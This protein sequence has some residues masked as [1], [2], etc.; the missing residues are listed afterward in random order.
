MN[1]KDRLAT[2]HSCLRVGQKSLEELARQEMA[3]RNAIIAQER[4]QQLEDS[5]GV[6]AALYRIITPY[7]SFEE[8]LAELAENEPPFTTPYAAKT[9]TGWIQCGDFGEA[10]GALKINVGVDEAHQL[11]DNAE[12]REG[13]IETGLG[14]RQCCLRLATSEWETLQLYLLQFD[15]EN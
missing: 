3:R 2:D 14:N 6:H 7:T 9:P 10:V 1:N 8:V 4:N 5:L 11:I 13:Y 12:L 15:K